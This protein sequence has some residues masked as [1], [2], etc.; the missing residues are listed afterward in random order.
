MPENRPT[1]PD[2]TVKSPSV[3]RTL[4]RWVGWAT[5]LTAAI[6]TGVYAAIEGSHSA[7]GA[8]IGGALVAAFFISGVALATLS[9]REGQP[10]GTVLLLA[11]MGY[12]AQV[13]GL[14]VLMLIF[15]RTTLFDHRAFGIAILIGTVVALVASVTG[16]LRVKIVTIVPDANAVPREPAAEFSPLPDRP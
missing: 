9:T 3:R 11:M 16:F 8:A 10:E 7:V 14:F 5:M 13:I 15:R 12:G 6:V 4:M 2:F 1:A